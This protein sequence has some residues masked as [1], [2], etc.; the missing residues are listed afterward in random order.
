MS[1]PDLFPIKESWS[2][3]LKWMNNHGIITYHDK[4]TGFL[5]ET[6]EDFCLGDAIRRAKLFTLSTFTKESVLVK[7]RRRP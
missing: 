3:K 7:L 6:D 4:E 2:P 5:L 1:T